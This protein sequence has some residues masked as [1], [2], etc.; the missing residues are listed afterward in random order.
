M[1]AGVLLICDG[2]SQVSSRVGMI[3]VY[4]ANT[5]NGVKVSIALEEMGLPYEIRPV[6]IGRGDQFK[7]DFL[8]IA[9]NNR[10]PAIVDHAPADGG[11][12]RSV[13]AA[14]FSADG[15]R[16]SALAARA[17]RALST[18]VASAVRAGCGGSAVAAAGGLGEVAAGGAGAADGGAAAAGV[19]VAGVGSAVAGLET[20][21]TR[22]CT[23]AVTV[24]VGNSSCVRCATSTATTPNVPTIIHVPVRRVAGGSSSAATRPA[25]PSPKPTPPELSP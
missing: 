23:C 6:N 22:S 20:A 8:A 4:P 25:T 5:P 7:P 14:N 18:A 2:L 13:A 15:A 1:V 12:N 24:S 17:L 9:P 10:I 16:A 19:P 11:A 21:V 3:D